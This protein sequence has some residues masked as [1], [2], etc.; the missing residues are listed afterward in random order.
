[1]PKPHR[2]TSDKQPVGL[3]WFK[4]D[5]RVSDHAALVT[6]AR[7]VNVLPLYIIEPHILASPDSDA[8]HYRFVRE[9]VLALRAELAELGQP[10]I[11]RVGDAVEVLSALHAQTQFVSIDAHEETGNGLTYRRDV[12]VAA[13][14]RTMNVEFREHS[15]NGVVRRLASRDGW[16][17][18]W[19]ARMHAPVVSTPTALRGV[20][21]IEPGPVPDAGALGLSDLHPAVASRAQPQ[22]G[23]SAQAHTT[24]GSFLASRGERYQREISAPEVARR[25]CSRISPYLAF[26]C[27]SL[28]EVVAATRSSG[29]PKRAASAFQSRLHWHCHFM[30]KLESQPSIETQCFNPAYEHLRDDGGDADLFEAW[31]TGTTGYPFVDACMRALQHTGWINFRMRAMLTS[32]AAWD[33]WLD[34]RLLRDFLARQFIDYEPGIHVSQLQMQSGVTGIN[35]PRMYNPVKQG[36]D[37][38]PRGD[39]VR[40]WVTELAQVPTLFIHEPWKMSPLELAECDLRLGVDYPL[41]VVDHLQAV[42]AARARLAVVRNAPSHRQQSGRVFE[43]HGSRR[44]SGD[45]RSDAGYRKRRV[46]G[47]DAARFDRPKEDDKQLSLFD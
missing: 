4:R 25:S 17:R 41:P 1:M 44:G 40:R 33:L 43:R 18:I 39:F 14:A 13:W 30:Q 45:G 27:I 35:T 3:V 38:D 19:T 20:A 32:F 42:R 5:L 31:C 2:N 22:Q 21:G 34:W 23:G 6:A 46:A 12:A 15:Q 37:H 47:N 11:V 24:L 26:G 8:M 36:L 10:L 9:S 7:A 28:R 16:S 29:L